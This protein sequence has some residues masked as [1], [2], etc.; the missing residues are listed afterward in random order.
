MLSR[1]VDLSVI[2]YIVSRNWRCLWTDINSVAWDI[3]LN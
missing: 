3:K 2:C 1:H